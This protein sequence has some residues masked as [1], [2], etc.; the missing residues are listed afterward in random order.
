MMPERMN[1]V[2]RPSRMM[3]I[4]LV[5]ISI[6]SGCVSSR[7]PEVKQ[8]AREWKAGDFLI[9]F[10]VVPRGA[11]SGRYAYYTVSTVSGGA[12]SHLIIDSAH[13][14]G[15]FQSTSDTEPKHHIRI[16]EDPREQRILIEEDI[17][18]SVA[19]CKN[20]ILVHAEANS[21]LGFRYLQLPE[22]STGQG[23]VDT[24][25]PTVM[26]LEG[27]SITYIYP[28]GAEVTREIEDI[29]SISEP[30]PAG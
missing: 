23:G 24:Q 27:K 28:N 2:I 22:I 26:R 17:P 20:Y 5:L 6:F 12:K 14:I 3:A 1:P 15:G 18:N 25:M 19:P 21:R 16:V 8:F 4:G 11:L 13:S 30:N 7:T 9:S 29:E 10:S